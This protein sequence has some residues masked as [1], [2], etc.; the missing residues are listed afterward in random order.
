M[1][2]NMARDQQNQFLWRNNGFREIYKT[3]KQR[4]LAD[5]ANEIASLCKENPFFQNKFSSPLNFSVMVNK[6]QME[7]QLKQMFGGKTLDIDNLRKF[8]RYSYLR[9]I[10]RF[11][12]GTSPSE[13]SYE[14]NELSDLLMEKVDK[15]IV[16]QLS[17]KY[18]E[19]PLRYAV[20]RFGSKGRR[21][22]DL[23]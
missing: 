15:I 19:P 5:Q 20:A 21:G 2:K 10:V 13:I 17:V 14:Y 11:V 22:S 8:S 7:E 12:L 9:N 6:E 18:G 16:S 3:L 23:F 1:L 4:K